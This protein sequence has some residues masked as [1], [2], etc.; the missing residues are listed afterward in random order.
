M[1]WKMNALMKELIKQEV[2]EV[3]SNIERIIASYRH[4][5]DIYTELLQNAADAVLEHHGNLESGVISLSINTSERVVRVEDNGVG[6]AED[7]IS[8]IL[9]NGKS[10]KRKRNSGKFGFMGFGFTFI[11]FQSSE[12][13]IES[14]KDGKYSSRTYSDLYKF[15]YNEGDL[16]NSYEEENNITHIDVPDRDNGTII[17]VKFP[18]DFPNESIEQTLQSAFN[19]CSNSSIFEA[20]IRTKTVVGNLEKVFDD[21]VKLFNFKASIDEEEI[22]VKTG[23]MSIQEIVQ[24]ILKSDG[25][26]Y[27]MENYKPIIDAT[28]DL[29]TSIQKQARKAIVLTD[30]ARDVKIGTR[31]AITA[32][33]LISATSKS[34]VNSFNE[35]I[36]ALNGGFAVEHGTWLSIC[37]MPIGVCIDPFDHSNYLPFT[38]ICDIQDE[39]IRKELDAGRKGISSYRMEQIAEKA[40]ELL[41]DRNFIKYR[42]YVVGGADQRI[43]NPLYN[44]MKELEKLKKE[45]TF[46]SIGLVNSYLPPREEQ[47]VIS[48]F[49]EL[50]AIGVL[51]GYSAQVM[52]GFQVYDGLFSYKLKQDDGNL[53]SESN[54][55]GVYQKIFQQN[56]G[57][58]EKDILVEFKT[59]LG[60][61][62]RDVE[63]NKKDVSQIDILV[64]WDAETTSSEDLQK[65]KGDVLRARDV[66]ENVFYGVTHQLM[67]LGRQQS[68]LPIIS[69]KHIIQEK[70][71][72]DF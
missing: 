20:V 19:L 6:L 14:V 67:G 18:S 26:H 34:H 42:G 66:T 32:N 1:E 58:L 35:S 46:H 4:D 16:P 39:S 48:I 25:Q 38:V 15:V 3:K 28:E 49:I 59:N 31:N 60:Q 24:R 21:N 68:A 65:E 33:F 70:Y 63:K 17:T 43:T 61:I 52:S 10:L 23:Y 56:G 8:K 7:D 37:G 2:E 69:L 57:V 29:P 30:I 5:W 12:L 53:Y 62:Y 45:K 22:L 71:G 50:L 51:I 55:Y 41:V 40:R 11:A 36:G 27:T 54:K 13:K 44:P 9:V 64:C 47:E 72:I